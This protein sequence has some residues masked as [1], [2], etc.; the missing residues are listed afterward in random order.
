[1]NTAAPIDAAIF[2][3]APLP[4]TGHYT[5]TNTLG[6]IRHQRYVLCSMSTYTEDQGSATYVEVCPR[7]A[8]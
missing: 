4:P 5:P 2:R 8:K 1:M 7:I 3:L 6:P